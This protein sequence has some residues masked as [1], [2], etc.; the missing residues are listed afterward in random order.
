MYVASSLTWTFLR[1]YQ[2]SA[3]EAG[4]VVFLFLFGVSPTEEEKVRK[5]F[6]VKAVKCLDYVITVSLLDWRTN[7]CLIT[8]WRLYT[9]VQAY[10][11][12]T[13]TCLLDTGMGSA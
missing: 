11:N 13:E 10:V 8:N 7:L 6:A 9:G 12:T 1:L 5:S 4:L 2:F 3:A